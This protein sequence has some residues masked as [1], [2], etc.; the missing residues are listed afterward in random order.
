MLPKGRNITING[1]GYGHDSQSE[2]FNILPSDVM[3][4]VARVYQRQLS[5]LCYKKSWEWR[6][7]NISVSPS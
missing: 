1:R 3:Q 4:R 5:Y 7:K 2:C 6:Q